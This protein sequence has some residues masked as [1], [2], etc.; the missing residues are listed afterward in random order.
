MGTPATARLVCGRGCHFGPWPARVASVS[1]LG[2]IKTLVS[3]CLSV[4]FREAGEVKSHTIHF[5]SCIVLG[6]SI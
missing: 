1:P 5:A 4:F 3:V 6:R 2:G